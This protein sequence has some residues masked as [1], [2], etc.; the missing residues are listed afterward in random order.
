MVDLRSLRV[1]R[2][3]S[4]LS[5]TVLDSA[6]NGRNFGTLKVRLLAANCKMASQPGGPDRSGRQPSRP[7]FQLNLIEIRF[8]RQWPGAHGSNGSRSITRRLS[9]FSIRE[10]LIGDL[11][12]LVMDPGHS[13]RLIENTMI[14]LVFMILDVELA[15]AS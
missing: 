6:V 4:G 8:P 11:A 14:A 1:R 15:M 12:A 7:G 13:R 10:P 2:F 3:R 9:H 5:C